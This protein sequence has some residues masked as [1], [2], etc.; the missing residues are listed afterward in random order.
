[1]LRAVD[2]GAGVDPRTLHA[3]I[4]TQPVTARFDA[5]RGRILVSTQG[6]KTGRHTLLLQV[7]DHQEA[8]NNENQ[9]RILP[10]TAFVRAAFR[11]R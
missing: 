8:K 2:A 11:L 5:A 10:N 3:W 9:P 4:D 6:L 7:S 1:V